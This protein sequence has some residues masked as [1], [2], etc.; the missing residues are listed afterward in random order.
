MSLHTHER[1]ETAPLVRHVTDPNILAQESCGWTVERWLRVD[2]RVIYAITRVCVAWWLRLG[3]RLRYYGTKHVPTSGDVLACQ[4]H[5]SW[6]DSWIGALG[7]RRI[8]RWM[9][10]QEVVNWPVVG[11]YLRRG[12][13]FPV[14]RGAG[15]GTAIDMAKLML[16][17]GQFVL[18]YPEGTRIRSSHQLGPARRGAARLAL[19]AGATVLPMATYGLKPGTGREYLPRMLSW[20]PFARRVTTVF[21]EPIVVAQDGAASVERVGELRDQIWEEVTRLYEL[22]REATVSRRPPATI[23]PGISQSARHTSGQ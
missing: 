18:V 8:P 9:G 7:H 22:A 23:D 6:L 1:G 19:A 13:V 12:G 21:G 17:D 14:H 11:W 4:N 16:E 3:W 10:K 5:S 15:D 20:L 2:A